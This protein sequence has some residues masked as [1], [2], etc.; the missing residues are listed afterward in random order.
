MSA[1]IVFLIL[2]G[3]TA[4]ADLPFSALPTVP[5]IGQIKIV[6]DGFGGW[7]I[8]DSR[9]NTVMTWM[10]PTTPEESAQKEYPRLQSKEQTKTPAQ[11]KEEIRQKR[12]QRKMEIMRFRQ[13]QRMKKMGYVVYAKQPERE[14]K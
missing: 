10:R 1:K 6:P 12:Y 2:A 9:Q 8:W 11:K 5:N 4:I 7:E 13:I 3:S 14:K